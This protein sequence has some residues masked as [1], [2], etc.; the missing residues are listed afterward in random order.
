ME[1]IYWI[2]SMLQLIGV[3]IL[4][5]CI[6]YAGFLMVTAGGN[7]EQ[8]TKSKQWIAWT[9]VGALIVLGAKAIAGMA[10]GTAFLFD[11]TIVCP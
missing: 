11:A 8:I 9:L 6:V 7:E 4:V 1:F 5:C 3:P 2:I 10:C